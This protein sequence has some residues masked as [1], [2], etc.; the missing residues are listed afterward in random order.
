MVIY[1]TTSYH[2]NFFASL[3]HT[4]HSC[5]LSLQLTFFAVYTLPGS[6]MAPSNNSGQAPVEFVTMGMFILGMLS[7]MPVSSVWDRTMLIIYIHLM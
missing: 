3:Q 6:T 4:L 2:N 1:A 7:D 5:W